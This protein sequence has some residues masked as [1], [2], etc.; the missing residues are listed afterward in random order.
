[1]IEQNYSLAQAFVLAL[2]GDLSTV[3]DWRAIHDRDRTVA[4]VPVRG[5]LE[6]CWQSLCFWN[7]QGYGIFATVNAL[8]GHGREIGNVVQIRAHFVDLDNL[9]AMENLQKACEWYPA[10]SFAV[11]SS[12]NKAHL[13]W[14]IVPYLD[15]DKF[16][17]VQRRLRKYFDG[18]KAVIDA[19][20]VMRVP[21]FW[22]V[23]GEPVLVTCHA[24]PG[25]GSR[26]DVT[27]LE[28]ALA[29]VDVGTDG[30]GARHAL[31]DPELA[32]PSLEW[33]RAV[34]DGCDP[35]TLSRGDWI[36]F[37]AGV[38][39]AGWTLT[40][41][42]T[43][44][45]I[46]SD[47]CARYANNDIGENLKQ[48]HSIRNTELGWR[49][50]LRRVP[51]VHA[52]W[53]F[54][55][56]TGATPMP[57]PLPDCA[58][59]ILTDAE[60]RVWFKGCVF[61]ERFGEILTPTGRMMNATKFNGRYGGKKFIID[62]QAKVTDEAWKAATR[63]TLWQIPKADHL[64][65]LPHL[66]PGEFVTDELGRR[67]VN[68]YRPAIIAHRP[69]D[70]SLFMQHFALMIPDPGDRKIILD[71]I[72]HNVRFPGYKI[73]WAPLIQS[74]EGVGKGILKQIIR[75]CIGGPYVHFPNA[76]ELIE[77][78]SKF[79][80]WMRSKLFIICDE[81]KVD[82]RRDMIEVLKPMISEAEIEIQGKGHD[83][84]KEDNYS[85][86]MFFSN[87]KDAIPVNRN[88]RRFSVNYSP[89]QSA[90]DLQ[91]RGMNDEYFNRLM[92]W[93]NSGGCEIV[94]DYFLTYPIERGAIP[95]R[96]PVTTSTAEAFRQSRGPV[97][98]VLIE[99]IE[100]GLP[101]FRS[102]YVSTIAALAR[103]KAT[104]GKSYSVKTITSILEGLGYVEIGRAPRAYFP[105]DANNR[106]TV[107]ALDRN[108]AP[109]AYGR[110]QG[111][112]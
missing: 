40:D 55:A 61:V 53:S 25:Y 11:M 22:H 44:Y 46:W 110:A 100:D 50:L 64:R 8:D 30:G 70:P 54:G 104:L 36:A 82:E 23:K 31:G 39:Q 111:Y 16:T 85:N 112:E 4:G 35:N 57:M 76:Q 98:T 10:P 78:G 68:T 14:T 72:A 106:T 90:H 87:Y 103:V 29:G 93:L 102:G 26:V 94:A 17:L 59:E 27:M 95:M 21:G 20:R 58:G 28:I 66:A 83:Q 86:W 73:P 105:E 49:S 77:S 101:G 18:D 89:I 37:T 65:F 80:A 47:W 3:M 32:A 2:T 45:R 99:A 48:W 81:I 79:N 15:T 60:Q 84:D 75:H 12:P 7:S 33:L 52:M 107:Y 1:M 42:G 19:P 34:L 97:D 9:N 91:I 62:A 5:T 24:L 41:E 6:Q 56:K 43:L 13:Y 69:G 67:G 38:K 92:A 108:A 63:S 51:S 74:A 88:G 96:A 109:D 71:Y